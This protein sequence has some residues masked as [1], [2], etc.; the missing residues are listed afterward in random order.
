MIFIFRYDYIIMIEIIGIMVTQYQRL[1]NA[2]VVIC[3]LMCS[4]K[5]LFEVHFHITEAY[6][7]DN[8]CRNVKCNDVMTIVM[9]IINYY[10]I[11]TMII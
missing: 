2:Y 7:D 6:N 8:R 4:K 1:R 9:V 3:R 11:L 10:I 5:S